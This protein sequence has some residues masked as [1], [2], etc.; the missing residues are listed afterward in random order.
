MTRKEALR[1][2]IIYLRELQDD[3]LQETIEA[4]EDLVLVVPITQ[5]DFKTITDAVEDFYM[6]NGRLPFSSEFKGGELPSH[7]SLLNRLQLYPN[8]FLEMYFLETYE[9]QHSQNFVNKY[10]YKP[11]EY[12]LEQFTAFM[13]D[14]PTMTL[15]SYDR[16]RKSGM[17][18]SKT[19][20]TLAEVKTWN[21]LLLKVGLPIK[22]TSKSIKHTASVTLDKGNVRRS[23]ANLSI[24][25]LTPVISRL[26]NYNV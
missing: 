9:M 24:E 7:G 15:R 25:E 4:L 13:K 12:W 16:Y 21:Q 6:Q 10:R 17:P 14:N 3:T 23:Y 26:E 20:L 2:A 8:E 19:L 22:C 11:V 1:K 5:W 18:H